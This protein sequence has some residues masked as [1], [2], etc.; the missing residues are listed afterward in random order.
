MLWREWQGEQAVN[1]VNN[2]LI[3]CDRGRSHGHAKR[4]G[5][6][7]RSPRKTHY[8]QLVSIRETGHVVSPHVIVTNARKSTRSVPFPVGNGRARVKRETRRIFIQREFYATFCAFCISA[9]YVLLRVTLFCTPYLLDSPDENKT[10]RVI[11]FHCFWIR[12]TVP[13]NYPPL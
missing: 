4:L 2:I 3:H 7:T 9:P 5:I 11:I 1:N 13:T 10:L 12:Y 8:S 6:G